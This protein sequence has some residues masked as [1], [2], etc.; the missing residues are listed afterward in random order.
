MSNE[1]GSQ[2]SQNKRFAAVQLFFILAAKTV[3]EMTVAQTS[4]INNVVAASLDHYNYHIAI[5]H[6]SYVNINT[7]TSKYFNINSNQVIVLLKAI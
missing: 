1:R 5:E 2:R 6:I 3:I 4:S 7:L